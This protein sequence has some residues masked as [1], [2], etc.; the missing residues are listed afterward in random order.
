MVIIIVAIVGLYVGPKMLGGQDV[1]AYVYQNRAI[2]ILRNMQT[3]AMQDT[4]GPIVNNQQYCYQVNFDATN[5]QFGIP[6]NSFISQNADDVAATCNPLVVDTS[7]ARALFYVSAAELGAKNIRVAA[8]GNNG[9]SIDMIRFDNMGRANMLAGAN[10][11]NSCSGSN[12][13]RGCRIVF[14]GGSDSRVCVESEGYIYA[15]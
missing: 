4:R 10:H 3:R 11:F 7:D 15:C 2:S 8:Q 6:A 9:Q 1:A 12:V 5:N 14:S 13:P